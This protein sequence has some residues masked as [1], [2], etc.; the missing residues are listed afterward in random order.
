MSPKS[1]Q[2]SLLNRIARVLLCLMF[3]HSVIG[4]LTGFAVIAGAIAAKGPPWA[5][6][7]LVADQDSR[8]QWRQFAWL[9]VQVSNRRWKDGGAVWW[10]VSSQSWVAF[11]S[12]VG[13]CGGH[14]LL[15]THHAKRP[16][17]QMTRSEPELISWLN[18]GPG[19]LMSRTGPMPA[20]SSIVHSFSAGG[21]LCCA[22]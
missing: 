4:K 10:R 6:L 5:P 12:G 2:P 21:R 19:A 14:G 16:L 11:R 7:L 9:P 22:G 18:V 15:M 13:I 8:V 17:R 3:I 20:W 1:H